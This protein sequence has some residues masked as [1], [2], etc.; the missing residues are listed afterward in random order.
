MRNLI[1]GKKNSR[2]AIPTGAARATTGRVLHGDNCLP[3]TKEGK[4]QKTKIQI[5]SQEKLPFSLHTVKRHDGIRTVESDVAT[6]AIDNNSL[7]DSIPKV[8]HVIRRSFA[9]IRAEIKVGRG[10]TRL[11][12]FAWENIIFACRVAFSVVF[13]LFCQGDARDVRIAALKAVESH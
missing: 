5:L 11:R 13:L 12:R 7:V 3:K 1:N 9:S 4:K 8:K 10:V 2:S 6:N